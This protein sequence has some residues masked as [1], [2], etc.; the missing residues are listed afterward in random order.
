[1]KFLNATDHGVTVRLVNSDFKA[2]IV[3]PP[4]GWYEWPDPGADLASQRELYE[5]TRIELVIRPADF[6]DDAVLCLAAAE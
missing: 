2:T 5:A 6:D 3:V 4:N 1:M